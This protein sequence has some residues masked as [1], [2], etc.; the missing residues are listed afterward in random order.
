MRTNCSIANEMSLFA[1]SKTLISIVARGFIYLYKTNILWRPLNSILWVNIFEHFSNNFPWDWWMM[2]GNV[3]YR[4]NTIGWLIIHVKDISANT[5]WTFPL[6]S[7]SAP[8]GLL[9]TWENIEKDYNP[10]YCVKIVLFLITL[11][12]YNCFNHNQIKDILR[13]IL[14]HPVSLVLYAK[15]VHNH[16]QIYNNNSVI[17]VTLMTMCFYGRLVVFLI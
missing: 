10:G 15:S 5:T 7:G 6:L 8:C 17:L 3:L 9:S 11:I 4:S 1:L 12:P 16:N 14:K 2:N 13:N